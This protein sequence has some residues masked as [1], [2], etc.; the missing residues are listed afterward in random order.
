MWQGAAVRRGWALEGLIDRWEHTFGAG[1]E[2]GVSMTY[3]VEMRVGGADGSP[4]SVMVEV[5]QREDGVVPAARLGRAVAKAER[6]F[7]EM[8]AG[9]RPVAESLVEAFRGM[10]D[11]PEHIGVEFGLSFTTQADVI[12]SSASGQATF[13]VTLAWSEPPAPQPAPSP[14]QAAA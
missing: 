7:G 12:I 13:K 4:Q 9:I 14:A 10:A 6:S 5:E 8:L 1:I 3:L 2:E 11:A